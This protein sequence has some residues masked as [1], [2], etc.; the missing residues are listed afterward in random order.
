MKTEPRIK[1]QMQLTKTG[2]VAACIAMACGKPVKEIMGEY[3]H[4]EDGID[5]HSFLGALKIEGVPYIEYTATGFLP[6]NRVFIISVPSLNIQGHTHAIVVQTQ[7][8][9]EGGC[10]ILDPNSG[11]PGAKCYGVDQDIVSFG[12]IVEI[13]PGEGETVEN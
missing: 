9:E 12:Q 13:F 8:K 5:F 7:S 6:Y 11:R 4:P 3:H 10:F 1:S 2:C